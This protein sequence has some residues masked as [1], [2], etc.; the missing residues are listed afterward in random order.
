MGAS[1]IDFVIN[2]IE[3]YIVYPVAITVVTLVICVLTMLSVKHIN[4]NAVNNVE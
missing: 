1:H 4:T 3:I 2:P